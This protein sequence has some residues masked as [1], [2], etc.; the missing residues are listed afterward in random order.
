MRIAIVVQRY[1]TDVVGGA[2]TLTRKIAEKLVSEL[3]WEVDVITTTARDYQTWSDYYSSGQSEINGVTVRRFNSTLG[4]SRIFPYVNRPLATLALSLGKA[5]LLTPLARLLELSWL[6]LQGPVNLKI[7]RYLKDNLNNY[8]KFM[9]VTYLYLPALWGINITRD[10]SVLVPTAHDEAPFYFLTVSRALELT[11]GI[12]ANSVPEQELIAARGIPRSKIGIAGLGIEGMEELSRDRIQGDLHQD[13]QGQP[14]V[15][16]LGRLSRGKQVDRLISMFEA[17]HESSSFKEVRL[18]L[19]G[20]KEDDVSLPDGDLVEYV[21]FLPD[22]RKAAYI[23]NAA[24]VINP[25][26]LE[27]LSLIVVEAMALEVPVLVNAASAA[28][29]YYTRTT[30]TVF[31]YRDEKGFI[32]QLAG[33]LGRDWRDASHSKALAESRQWVIENY[34]WEKIL[35]EYRRA[36]MGAPQD[37]PH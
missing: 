28:L 17:F 15:L 14:Y 33:I 35:D 24:C 26:S 3:S 23:A 21:G 34:S 30:R 6:I 5:A 16:Y 12:L 29:A 2:E 32:D 10:K 11:G 27:S 20:Q 37:P 31:G 18:V 8:D 9:F 7:A 4:R 36:A 13:L 25:S 19:A 22:D 1:G